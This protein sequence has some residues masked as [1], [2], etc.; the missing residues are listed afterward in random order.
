MSETPLR[1]D[2]QG[3]ELHLHPQGVIWW[4]ATRTLILS[5]VHLGKSATFRSHGLPVPEGETLD[6]L[7]R[8]TQLVSRFQAESLIIV[9]D[10]F[11]SSISLTDQ[12]KTTLNQWL[13]ELPSEVVLIVGNHDPSARKLTD[14]PLLRATPAYQRRALHFVHDPSD[15][16]PDSPTI[17]GHLHP[18]CRIGT[19]AGPA[20]RVR[21]FLLSGPILTLPAFGTFTSGNLVRQFPGP[22]RLF[23]IIGKLVCHHPQNSHPS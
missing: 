19:Q 6:D 8:I 9:G 18:L 16:P 21:C 22:H 11:H 2:F 1:I 23:P 20:I 15:A 3:E 7:R 12:F 17:T 5:D 14:F 10:F 4:T 13:T